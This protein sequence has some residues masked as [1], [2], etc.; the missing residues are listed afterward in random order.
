[1]RR[2]G[3][4]T[5]ALILLAFPV[6]SFAGVAGSDHDLTLSGEKLCFACHIPHNALGDKLWAQ[7]PSGTF[8]GV[9]DL[10]YTCH[11]GSVTTVGS[12]TAFNAAL[13]QHTNVGTDCSG[14]G[15]CHDVH[16]QNPNGTGRFLV[17]SDADADGAY[18]DEC[19]GATPF[20]GAEGLGD[21]TAGITH[22]TAGTAPAPAGFTCNG[23]HTPHGATAQT[24]NPPGL[25]NPILLEDN[26]SGAFYGEFC[27]SCHN[28]VAPAEAVTGTG[29]IAAADVFDYSEATND[30]TETKHPS[31]S[32]TGTS[33]I[34]GC[35]A[36]HDVHDPAGTE[37]GY[38]LKQDNTVS[39][40]CTDCHTSG[41]LNAP[42]VGAN[43]HYTG[44]PTDITIN[45]GLTPPLPYAQ[46]IDDDGNPGGDWVGQPLLV[47]NAVVCETC[48][49]VHRN[50]AASPGGYFLRHENTNNEICQACH[51]A[52]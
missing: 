12:G 37:Y 31:T 39:A 44:V 32:T 38:I 19:H 3:L 8:T 1:M 9:Q 36:C 20:T 25:T 50:G 33:P 43:T 14:A 21:H 42:L 2:L 18:C 40:F 49:S 41:T 46:E 34:G 27:I 15:A 47:N 51:S 24:T 30:G 6:S 48:H 29:G 10:C 22:V 13:E 16:N 4:L 17:V 23:C 5:T 7:T 11:D 35:N 26:Q 45:N 28:G 52:N